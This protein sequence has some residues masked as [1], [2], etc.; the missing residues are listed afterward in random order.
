MLYL[1]CIVM[2]P[3]E[4]LQLQKK[5]INLV[6]CSMNWRPPHAQFDSCWGLHK[7]SELDQDESSI[8]RN[9][10][11]PIQ[12]DRHTHWPSSPSLTQSLTGSVLTF[13]I[14]RQVPS[15]KK[16]IKDPWGSGHLY[17]PSSTKIKNLRD[18]PSSQIENF[19]F[20][21][22]FKVAMKSIKWVC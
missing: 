5:S 11:P 9:W 18:H 15:C 19:P 12:K 21:I 2:M 3:N 10:P 22:G 1:G 17:T 16:H 14:P 13:P 8:S 6:S 4:K 20:S 7:A